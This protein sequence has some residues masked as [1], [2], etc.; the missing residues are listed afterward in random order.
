MFGEGVFCIV[1]KKYVQDRTLIAFDQI[2]I[3][4]LTIDFL[5]FLISKQFRK[6]ETNDKPK[7]H[8]KLNQN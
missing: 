1:K 4:D 8:G 3:I 6:N 7:P 5:K 2:R